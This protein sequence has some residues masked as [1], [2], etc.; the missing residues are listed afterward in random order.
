MTLEIDNHQE[1]GE[2]WRWAGDERKPFEELKWLITST[3]ILVQ[4]D[5][6]VYFQLD[7][8]F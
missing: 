6:D 1:K 2:A 8:C 4:P 3:P 5:Q 7:R